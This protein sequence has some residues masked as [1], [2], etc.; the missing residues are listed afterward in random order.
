MLA[1]PPD[2]SQGL[3]KRRIHPGQVGMLRF[4][5][6]ERRTG[7]LVQ[8]SPNGFQCIGNLVDDGFEQADEGAEAAGYV[9]G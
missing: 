6:L 9:E 2:R 4:I 1:R 7:D 3:A 5:R 8:P